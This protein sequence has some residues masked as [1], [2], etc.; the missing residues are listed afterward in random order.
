MTS[1][2]RTAFLSLALLAALPCARA[3]VLQD[4]PGHWMG[5][6]KLPDGHI[7]K[8]GAELFTR[9]DGSAWASIASPDQGAYDIPVKAVTKEGND[10]VLLDIGFG[11]MQ[12][13]WV[14]D[15]FQAEWRQGEDKLPIELRRVD[16]FPMPA[17]LQTPHAPFPYRDETLAIRS[18]N[19]VMLGA[20]LTLPRAGAGARA[21]AKP[22]VVVVVGGSGPSTRHEEVA[23]HKLFDV[24]ADHLARGGLAV[25]RY[26]KRGVA[27]ST[28]DYASHTLADLEDDAYAVVEALAKRKQFASI[29]LAGHSEGSQI[30]AAVAA[31]HPEAV[32][33]V[34]SLGGVGLAGI[35]LMMLQ[36]SQW[37]RDHGAT[38]EQLA[39]VLPYVR[40]YYDT[41][42]ATPDGEARIAALKAVYAALPQQDQD[43]VKT[44]SMN[45]GTLSPWMA[46]QPSLPVVLRTDP[47][48]DW[49]KVRCPVLV[50][51]GSLDHQ[52][53]PLEDQAGIVDALQA[54]GNRRVQ[55]SVLPSLNHAFQTARTG[56]EDEYA[57][58][59]ETMAPAAMQKIADFA[60]A[61]DGRG[62]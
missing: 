56:R 47:R 15:H 14:R 8:M 29:G 20:T 34:V 23:G 2:L 22:T 62:R 46:A 55:A 61:Q 25:L 53:P 10:G 1:R 59:D 38:P 33:F 50:L 54:G 24:L 16:A 18:K 27:R 40:K 4:H 31:R 45:E 42:L 26:D 32:D 35:D 9:A 57:T 58:I 48:Q 12:L 3:D 6:M 13:T 21:G 43:L 49:S 37:A 30:A 7:L 39:Q 44:L 5:D 60:R 41:V 19:G 51:N 28:G 11:A 36:D 52:V 17:R